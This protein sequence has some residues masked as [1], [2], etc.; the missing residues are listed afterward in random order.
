[1]YLNSKITL[2]IISQ[3]VL[4]FF[5]VAFN[6]FSLA[7]NVKTEGSSTYKSAY[8]E[9]YTTDG[10]YF[11]ISGS[12]NFSSDIWGTYENTSVF[13]YVD[14]LGFLYQDVAASDISFDIANG[15]V[16]INTVV[17]GYPVSVTFTGEKK[18]TRSRTNNFYHGTNIKYKGHSTGI[19]NENVTLTGTVAGFTIDV[20]NYASFSEYSSNWKQM[21]K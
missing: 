19:S 12:Y 9:G 21:E 6:S 8:G 15:V 14:G 20:I 4:L 2:K 1:M 13:L 11:Y 3:I 16:T 18:N 5:C 10:R 17:N 7:E